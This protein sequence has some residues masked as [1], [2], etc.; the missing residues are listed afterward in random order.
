[1][2]IIVDATSTQDQLMN[3][4]PGRYANEIVSN[5]VKQSVKEGRDDIYYLLLFNSPTTL[6]PVIS[7]YSENVRS[8]NI[9]KRRLSGKFNDIWWW[10]QYKPAIR[11]LIKTESPDLYFCSYF[12]R[13]FPIKKIPTVV[14]IHDFTYAITGRYSLA[15]KFLDWIRKWQY[16][17]TL[18]KLEKVDGVLTNS[19]NTARDLLKYVTLDKE[20]IKTIYLGI[21]DWVKKVRPRKKVLQKYLPDEVIDRGYVFY[22]AGADPIKNP[23]GLVRAYSELLKIYEKNN[24]DDFP[25][26]VMGGKCFT[27]SEVKNTEL[28]LLTNLIVELNLQDKIF[29]T[30]YYEDE[31]LDDLISASRCFMHLS[32]YEGFGISAL[33][34]MK[35]GA[36]LVASKMPCYSEVLGDGA[37][38][39]DPE[40]PSKVAKVTYELLNNPAKSRALSNRG[41]MWAKK[42]TW[43]RTAKE[44]Y[45]YFVSIVRRSEK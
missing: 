29:F 39:V 23:R 22:E 16:H 36:P 1:M 13:N 42:Y 2:K 45:K 43:E 34:A 6:Q 25:F 19:K 4:G 33:Q 12:W 9:G 18:N 14:M 17:K 3:R 40:N 26:L 11:K 15:Q 8:I 21:S 28:D 20:K 38:L 37:I 27:S 7:E 5:M 44:T 30:G 35:A 24:K 41:V 32:L 31:D 10:F